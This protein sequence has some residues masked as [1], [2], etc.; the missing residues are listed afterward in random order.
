MNDDT[1]ARTFSTPWL[2]RCTGCQV[3]QAKNCKCRSRAP[4]REVPVWLIQLA[5]YGSSV[6]LVVGLGVWLWRAW[7]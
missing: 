6:A 1:R 4:R 2:D 3:G 5:I 7:A